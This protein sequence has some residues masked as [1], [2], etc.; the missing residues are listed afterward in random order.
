MLP[1]LAEGVGAYTTGLPGIGA[2]GYKAADLAKKHIVNPITNKMGDA[3]NLELA[4]LASA[5]GPAKDEIVSYLSKLVA[6]T[7]KLSVFN[8]AKL[9]AG[10]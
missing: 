1:Y 4:R 2:A 10:P 6:P 7:P 3:K 8:R 9:I 5:T